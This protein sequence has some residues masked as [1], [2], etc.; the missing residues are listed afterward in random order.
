MPD[1]RTVDAADARVATDRPLR[2]QLLVAWLH[3]S[4][5]WS[6]AVA[7]PLFN[8]LAGDPAFFVARAN[9]SGD[10]LILAFAL[11]LVPPTVLVLIELVFARLPA[12]RSWLHTAFVG[13]LSA[14]FALQVVADAAPSGSSW[15]LVPLALAVG[16][17][18]ALAYRRT[19]LV[20]SMLTV[21]SPAPAVFL[22]MFLLF[23][24]VSKLVLP[25]HDVQASASV[26]GDTPVVFVQLDEFSGLHLLDR[27]G[28]INATRYPDFAA[29]AK[30]SDWYRNATTVSDRT[31]RAIPGILTGTRPSANKLPIVSDY[32]KNL[33]TLLGGDYRLDV[34][35]SAS[36]LCP[37]DLCERTRECP[38]ARRPA[39]ASTSST[40]TGRRS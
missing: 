9:T 1:G 38:S 33:F 31:D 40:T 20:P 27:D 11:V 28:G 19:R 35:E 4:V 10:I 24:D 13:L 14:V 25:E 5:L 6:F 18:A 8:V 37:D 21:L 26:E 36:H 2:T 22:A 34:H 39:L 16:A 32:P 3:L 29:L 7:Q 23:S 30:T 17:V 12:V 15:I